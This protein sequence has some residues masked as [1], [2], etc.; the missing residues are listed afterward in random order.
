MKLGLCGN[1][2]LA[3]KGV[4]QI[5]LFFFHTAYIINP[6]CNRGSG[7]RVIETDWAYNQEKTLICATQ[8]LSLL[9]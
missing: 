4:K 8:P 5:F 1:P 6:F 7:L 9:A 2:D 3:G